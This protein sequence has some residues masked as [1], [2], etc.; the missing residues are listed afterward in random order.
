MC[1]AMSE[2]GVWK[3]HE[4]ETCYIKISR[5]IV[6]MASIE[7]REDLSEYMAQAFM[8]SEA[9]RFLSRLD[10]RIEEREGFTT[11]QYIDEYIDEIRDRI[12]EVKER[13]RQ[14]LNDF[15]LDNDCA[16]V[17]LCYYGSTQHYL[18][19]FLG[20]D[21]RCYYFN[22][23]VSDM[24]PYTRVNKMYACFQKESDKTAKESGLYQK[25]IYLESHLT[26]PHGMISYIDE[27]GA[28]VCHESMKNQ[29]LFYRKEEIDKGV[30]EFIS[31]YVR[32]FGKCRLKPDCLFSDTYYAVSMDSGFKVS[33][34]VKSSFWFDN[35]LASNKQSPMY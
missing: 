8:G 32:R 14:Y 12:R 5:Q 4:M 10:I 13:Y 7:T 30:R 20:T 2:A 28:F 1:E 19:K 35:A 25:I 34:E 17:D 9:E 26:A 33:D 21:L 6:R 11:E 3:K 22:A 16:L 23:N 31:D 24:N 27:N 15:G 18:N 29:E